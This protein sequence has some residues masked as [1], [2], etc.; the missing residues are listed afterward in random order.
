[1]D[2]LIVKI[3]LPYPTPQNNAKGRMEA[4]LKQKYPKDCKRGLFNKPVGSQGCVVLKS[5][6]KQKENLKLPLFYDFDTAL[7]WTPLGQ[8]EQPYCCSTMSSWFFSVPNHT[9]RFFSLLSCWMGEISLKKLRNGRAHLS[10]TRNMRFEP[11]ISWSHQ[12]LKNMVPLR[13]YLTSFQL[14]FLLSFK[15][16]YIF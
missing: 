2:F 5:C 16:K 4:S 1:M 7:S 9:G 8:T 14:R 12:P 13:S 10:Q 11:R 3:C 6:I 15:K